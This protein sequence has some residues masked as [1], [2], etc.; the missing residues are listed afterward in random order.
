MHRPKDASLP[1]AAVS[2]QAAHLHLVG[3]VHSPS[4]SELL[5]KD[6]ARLLATRKLRNQLFDTNLFGEPAWDILLSLYV[7]HNERRRLSIRN[8]A[9]FCDLPLTT[10]QRWLDFLTQRELIARLPSP[11]DHRVV[12][13]EL[14]DTGRARMDNY[15]LRLREPG[16]LPPHLPTP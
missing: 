4:D 8:L 11:T 12:F 7:I 6:A 10:T 1:G 3:G 16:T 2:P 15:F 5:R 13:I 9:Q 14:S